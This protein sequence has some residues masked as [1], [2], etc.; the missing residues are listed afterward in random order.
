MPGKEKDKVSD[1][2]LG[3]VQEDCP[4]LTCSFRQGDQ[5]KLRSK[6]K[7]KLE[8]KLEYRVSDGNTVR[9]LTKRNKELEL[10]LEKALEWALIGKKLGPKDFAYLRGVLKPNKK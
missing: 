1:V 8:K 5:D 9:A 3:V 2:I 7:D 10:A 4:S 6:T